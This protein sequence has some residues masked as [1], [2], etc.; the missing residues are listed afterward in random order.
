M[1][2]EHGTLRREVIAPAYLAALRLIVRTEG[3]KRRPTVPE[4]A[5]NIVGIEE[6]C[7]RC[8]A[9]LAYRMLPFHRLHGVAR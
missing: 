5:E 2:H 3:A 8:R 7:W 1:K 4:V 6:T 9:T